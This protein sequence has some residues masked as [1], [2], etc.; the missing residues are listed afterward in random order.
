MYV[1]DKPFYLNFKVFSTSL[2][3]NNNSV[4]FINYSFFYHAIHCK[5]KSVS[6]SRTK[7][8]LTFGHWCSGQQVSEAPE[9]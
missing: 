9:G 2:I 6:D 1:T 3:Y 5:T 7:A 8:D 4:L